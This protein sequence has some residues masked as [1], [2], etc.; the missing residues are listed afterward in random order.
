MGLKWKSQ[1]STYTLFFFTFSPQRQYK[2]QAS[3]EA[4]SDIGARVPLGAAR[5]PRRGRHA[6]ASQQSRQ[7]RQR[8]HLA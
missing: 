3:L 8:L 7:P 5:R 6:A 1:K 4:L 2:W